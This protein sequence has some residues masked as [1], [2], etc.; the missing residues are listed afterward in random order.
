MAAAP[1]DLCTLADLKAWLPNQGN[2][3]DVTL[4]N[5]ITNGSL[6]VLQLINRP[7]ILASVLG[8]LT[9]NYDGN[10][11]DRLLPRQFPIV[12]VTALTIDAVPIPQ[13]TAPNV[14]GFL[15]DQRRV[16]LRGF[17][18]DRGVQNIQ[19]AYTA[20]Y[21]SVPLDLR[22][23]AIEAFALAYRQRVRIGEKSN[24]MN[25]QVTIAFDMSDVPPRSMTVFNQ[26]RRL[27]L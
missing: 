26:Y 27:A 3:D 5:L 2:N 23:A 12:A 22:Q 17:R 13:S 25:G 8:N 10:D 20:G 1:D 21:S 24:S 6:H 11:S 14:A 18:F 7:H 16:L 4:Q 15:W 9:E 19:L